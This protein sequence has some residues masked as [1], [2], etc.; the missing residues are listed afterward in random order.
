MTRSLRRVAVSDQIDLQVLSGHPLRIALADDASLRRMWPL[1][2]S[3]VAGRPAWAAVARR[4]CTGGDL[5]TAAKLVPFLEDRERQDVIDTLLSA[6]RR[7]REE[8]DQQSVRIATDALSWEQRGVNAATVHEWLGVAKSEANKLPGA[9]SLQSVED[10]VSFDRNAFGE[11]AGYLREARA[12]LETL[13]AEQDRRREETRQAARKL[14]R[15]IDGRIDDLMDVLDPASKGLLKRVASIVLSALERHDVAGLEK[16]LDGVER[17]AAGDREP[18]SVL[19]AEDNRLPDTTAGDVG[20]A[21]KP[22]SEPPSSRGSSPPASEAPAHVAVPPAPPVPSL[23]SFPA[24]AGLSPAATARKLSPLAEARF[25]PHKN[26]PSG[27]VDASTLLAEVT[28]SWVSADLNKLTAQ[29]AGMALRRDPAWEIALSAALLGDAKALLLDGDTPPAQALF[30]EALMVGLSTARIHDVERFRDTAAW[31]V[32]V[33]LLLPHMST[34]ERRGALDPVNL[35]MLFYR[36]IG[37]L[38]LRL[39]DDLNLLGALGAVLAA[40]EAGAAVYFSREYLKPYL[41]DR[42][43]AT[44][45]IALGLFS[46]PQASPVSAFTVLSMLLRDVEALLPAADRVDAVLQEVASLP[47]LRTEDRWWEAAERLRRKIAGLASENEA[48]RKL[49]EAI[50]LLQQKQKQRG[51]TP[52]GP[53]LSTR[54]LTPEPQSITRPYVVVEV[55]NQSPVQPV[56]HLRVDAAVVDPIERLEQKARSDSALATIAAEQRAELVIFVADPTKWPESPRLRVR[57]STATLHGTLAYEEATSESFALKPRAAEAAP[58]KKPD[59]PYAVGG[60]VSDRSAI[61]GRKEEVDKI[62]RSLIG[63][64]RD[65]VV[66]V[67]GE[68][69]MGKTTVLN[70]VAQETEVRQRYGSRVVRIDVQ[71]VPVGERTADFFVHRMVAPMVR[72][73]ASVGVRVPIV[74]EDFFEKSPYEAFKQFMVDLDDSVGKQRV[75]IVID[76]LEKLLT[77]TEQ[78][79]EASPQS[80]GTETMASLRAVMMQTKNVSFILAGVTDVLRRHTTQHAN[81]LFRLGI[82]IE[83]KSLPREAAEELVEQPCKAAYD[84]LPAA[85]DIIVGLT[86]RQPYLVQYICHHLFEHMVRSG[87]TIVTRTD[88]ERVIQRDILTSARLFEHFVEAVPDAIDAEIVRALGALQ[89]GDETVPVSAIAR[90][91]T[92][93]GTSLSEDDISKRL[94]RLRERTPAVVDDMIWLTRRFRLTVGLYARRLRMLQRDPHGLVVRAM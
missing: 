35:S 52:R 73:L 24:L 36:R 6:W 86:G 72:K 61:V 40:M 39:V 81:R 68:R 8:L 78:Q 25:A 55:W 56:R 49:E 2:L 27:G 47:G 94:L 59:N 87:A 4:A 75:L 38:P 16:L 67:L 64:K 84:V 60:A 3:E 12:A 90:H 29:A 69:R 14:K 15:E 51:K 34:E 66:V 26:V 76:E 30:A 57:F 92:R 63:E 37:E 70:A 65:N 20:A 11:V 19:I 42:P 18:L 85:R 21:Q 82:E 45:E 48:L 32:L 91:L 79:K 53:R 44:T 83:I 50:T 43:I 1:V 58:A 80:L 89:R 71:D 77:V 23:A 46:A 22:A 41:R 74:R 33:T 10:L 31:G 17:L 93:G 62:I 5:A 7:A 28:D 9:T 88:V 13:R 54:L